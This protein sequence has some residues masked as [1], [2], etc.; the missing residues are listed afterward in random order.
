MRLVG[1]ATLISY[2]GKRQR[3]ILLQSIKST[4]HAH[5][6]KEFFRSSTD[7]ISKYTAKLLGT[8][9]GYIRKL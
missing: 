3:R 1:K 5:N 7:I 2:L 9:A 8:E 4:L 6:T